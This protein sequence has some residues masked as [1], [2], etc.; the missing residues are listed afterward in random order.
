MIKM[1]KE[2]KKAIINWLVENENQWQRVNACT[3]NFRNYI[4]D[5][6]GNH[7]IGGEIVSTFIKD[8]EKLIYS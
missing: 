7:I 4:Y 8:A 6:N 3:E 1:N 5:S 2:L